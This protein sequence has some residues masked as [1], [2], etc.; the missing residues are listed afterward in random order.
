[1]KRRTRE[2]GA[3]HQVEWRLKYP[4]YYTWMQMKQRCYNPNAT[5][6]KNYGGRGITV[7]AEWRE[8]FQTFL[9][10]VGPRPEGKTMDRIN[11]DGN[12]EPGNVRWATGVEQI[13]NRRSSV[14]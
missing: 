8:S 7:F 14:S 6:Y 3:Q 10:Y 9:D 11:N 12:Y 5:S 13:A 4:L 1:M 2:E